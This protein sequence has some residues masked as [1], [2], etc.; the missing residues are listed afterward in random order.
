MTS[1][2]NKRNLIFLSLDDGEQ[3]TLKLFLN[4][5][6]WRKHSWS[7]NILITK[8]P[9][10]RMVQMAFCQQSVLNYC[11]GILPKSAPWIQ[12]PYKIKQHLRAYDVSYTDDSLVDILKSWR[13]MRLSLSGPRDQVWL[14]E[15][16]SFKRQ[17]YEFFS[18][19]KR[20]E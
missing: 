7:V 4:K 12:D 9:E 18:Y 2:R 10:F 11:R 17:S 19:L 16:S 6:I 8:N 14:H 20:A 15:H 5:L 1:F 13:Y 3:T